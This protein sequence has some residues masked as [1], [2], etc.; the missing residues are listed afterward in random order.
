MNQSIYKKHIYLMLA[1]MFLGLLAACDPGV[2]PEP[3]FN[4]VVKI[5]VAAPYTG[6]TADGGIQIWQGVE[7]A[8]DEANAAGGI[9]GKKIEV[10][11]ADDGASADKAKE[12]ASK[13]VAD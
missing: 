4:G 7:L 8:V 11:P 5:G 1:T 2:K 10:V 9:L 6:D 13:L 12:V 3:T